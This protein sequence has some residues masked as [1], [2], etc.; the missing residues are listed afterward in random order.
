MAWRAVHLSPTGITE[1]RRLSRSVDRGPEHSDTGD[2]GTAASGQCGRA[3]Q[4]STLRTQAAGHTGPAA[5]CCPTGP[6]RYAMADHHW[7][8]YPRRLRIV[9]ADYPSHAHGHVFLR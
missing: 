7:A 6:A 4:F 5:A 9:R 2:A 3:D 1:R 8:E